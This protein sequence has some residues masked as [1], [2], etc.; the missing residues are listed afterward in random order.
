MSLV[1][2]DSLQLPMIASMLANDEAVLSSRPWS[3]EVKH[4]LLQHYALKCNCKYVIII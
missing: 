1:V 4:S 3:S 2:S